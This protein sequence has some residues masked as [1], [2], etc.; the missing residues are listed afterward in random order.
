[1]MKIIIAE[2]NKS[3][4]EELVSK[5]PLKDKFLKAIRYFD[6]VDKTSIFG[7]NQ[8]IKRL[9]I[10]GD[11]YYAYRLNSQ[12]RML[13]STYTDDNG[14]QYVFI[15]DVVSHNELFGT[16]YLRDLPNIN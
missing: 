10:D 6:L 14:E 4:I 7:E 8:E 3:K 12:Y 9:S 13:F 16:Q 15:L 11:I 1:M 2:S 5:Q